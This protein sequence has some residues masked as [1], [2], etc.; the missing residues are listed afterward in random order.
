MF[1]SPDTSIHRTGMSMLPLPIKTDITFSVWRLRTINL[2]I[3]EAAQTQNEQL[4]RLQEEIQ[5]L[6]VFTSW[7]AILP[8]DISG[9]CFHQMN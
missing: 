5:Y 6:L 7:A 3:L 1:A 8:V 2:H 9:S 4:V